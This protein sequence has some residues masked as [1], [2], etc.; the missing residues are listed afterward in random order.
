MPKLSAEQIN[1]VKSLLVKDIRSAINKLTSFTED[2]LL[3]QKITSIAASYNSLRDKQIVGIVDIDT[4][5]QEENE[6]RYRIL[7]LLE[8]PDDIDVVPTNALPPV[9][10]KWSLQF[11][12]VTVSIVLVIP[13]TGYRYYTISTNKN[14]IKELDKEIAN[15]MYAIVDELPDWYENVLKNDTILNL[16]NKLLAPPNDVSIC[17]EKYKNRNLKSLM[18]ELEGCLDT[19]RERMAVQRAIQK[20]SSVESLNS[21]NKLVSNPAELYKLAKIVLEV[22]KSRWNKINGIPDNQW[23]ITLQEFQN[24]YE[25]NIN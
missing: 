19:P 17:N 1:L 2:K 25:T 12:V 16:S 13:F 10:P 9:A 8:S 21:Y 11:M 14:V 3:S 7:T 23:S 22:N 24:I 4:L 20:L 6:I 18:S 5:L 15:R